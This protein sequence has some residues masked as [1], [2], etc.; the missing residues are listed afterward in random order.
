MSSTDEFERQ[1]VRPKAGRTLI[2]GSRI[3]QNKPDRRKLY[4]DAV[5]VDMS[6]GPGVDV[7]MDLE[8]HADC[9]SLG[10]FEHIEC[11]SVLE[12]VKRPWVMAHNLECL[13]APGGTIYV[14]APFI[15][16]VHGY[17]DDYWRFTTSG[18]RQLFPSITWTAE[19]F[20]AGRSLVAG[21]DVPWVRENDW[22]HGAAT[23]ICMF[24]HK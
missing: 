11:M 21:K 1:Y 15:W 14:T 12:H 8:F 18:V 3:Y 2:V 22:P 20:A 17:P 5:G 13:L 7:V 9:M 4:P 24:G 16:K 23:E 19:A 6:E 10:H